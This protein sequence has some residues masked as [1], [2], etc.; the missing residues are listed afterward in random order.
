MTADTAI[1]PHADPFRRQDF[2]LLFDVL[3][4][5]PNGDPDA[6]GA[7]RIDTENMHGLVTDVAIK[8]KIRDYVD[9]DRGDAERYKIYIQRESYL[10]DTRQRIF[11][12]HLT[13][14]GAPPDQ[15]TARAL[16]TA[17]FFDVR[18]FGAV[19]TMRDH[20]AGQVRGPVQISFGR[21]IDPVLPVDYT[22]GRVAVERR[23]EE[24]GDAN[25][26]EHEAPRHGTFGTKFGLPYALYM[27]TGHWQPHYAAQTG[28][29]ADDL[30][31]LW[32]AL[33]YMWDLD[34]SAARGLM[35]CRG[36]YVFTHELRLGNAAAADLFD[37]VS[38][39]L[40][41]DVTVPRHF[42]DYVVAIDETKF[43]KG[44]TLTRLK[45]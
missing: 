3:D 1:A 40:G 45:E 36:L 2:V 10:S 44:V 37:R 21:S 5:N 39:E 31:L 25:G 33:Q 29:D 12:E 11:G 24:A 35:A 14:D 8:R 43:P 22:I 41:P 7:P 38:V 19:M 30:D 26:D 16:M 20:N 32:T 17:E 4:G 27:T 13:A 15:R 34:R 42:S 23:G 9:A 28:A 18:V 6:G